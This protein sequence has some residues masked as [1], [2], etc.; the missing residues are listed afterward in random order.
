[1]PSEEE[2]L[3]SAIS[4]TEL[5]LKRQASYFIVSIKVS[6]TTDQCLS[7]C[8]ITVRTSYVK[9]GNKKLAE[10]LAMESQEFCRE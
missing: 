5:P 2:S 9:G 3:R 10:Y 6:T 1:M 7:H 4:L 8:Q